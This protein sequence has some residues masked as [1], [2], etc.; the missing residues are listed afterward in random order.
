MSSD[1]IVKLVVFLPRQATQDR[2]AKKDKVLSL[3]IRYKEK[4]GT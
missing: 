2:S 1:E 4:Y 3:N